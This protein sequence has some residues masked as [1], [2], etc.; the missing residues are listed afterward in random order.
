MT[1]VSVLL[2]GFSVKYC[3]FLAPAS[4]FWHY[5]REISL[6]DLLQKKSVSLLRDCLL[7]VCRNVVSL[8]WTPQRSHHSRGPHS[9]R[10]WQTSVCQ[11]QK[12]QNTLQRFACGNNWPIKIAMRN[13][14]DLQKRRAAVR[15][16]SIF[17]CFG[18]CEPFVSHWLTT[19]KWVN[20]N[21]WHCLLSTKN[22]YTSAS[23]WKYLLAL[24]N[25]LFYTPSDQRCPMV[26][27]NKLAPT[28][29]IWLSS[30]LC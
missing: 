24:P 26:S 5:C 3:M 29:S 10:L 14:T 6:D 11:L 28:R 17:F 16:S 2:E 8:C 21:L 27:Q 1:R 4:F 23:V 20:V 9:E 19:W 18:I 7:W 13:A 25:P 15:D 30:I 12:E 22:M